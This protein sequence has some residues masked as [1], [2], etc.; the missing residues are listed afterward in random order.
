V[1]SLLT[2]LSPVIRCL[3]VYKLYKG[4]LAELSTILDSFYTNITND[5]IGVEVGGGG[6]WGA[7]EVVGFST[8]R[9]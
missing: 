5:H 2:C 7:T 3:S 8:C 1:L 4:K 6:D 9:S